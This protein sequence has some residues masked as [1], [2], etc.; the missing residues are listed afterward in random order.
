MCAAAYLPVRPYAGAFRCRRI[1]WQKIIP[2][3]QAWEHG[4]IGLRA[5]PAVFSV[6]IRFTASSDPH[7]SAIE[8]LHRA[9]ELR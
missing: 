7:V 1:G 6:H 3:R 5:A 2:K 9:G 4:S 8:S